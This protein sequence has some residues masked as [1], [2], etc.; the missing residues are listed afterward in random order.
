[1]QKITL[2]ISV[3]SLIGVMMLLFTNKKDTAYFLSAEVYNQFDY[4]LELEGELK[5]KENKM[6]STL[7]SLENDLKLSYE[8][9][10]S[11]TPTEDQLIA[12]ERSQRYFLNYKEKEEEKYAELAQTY[13][14]QIWDRINDFVKEYGQENDMAYIF[15]ANGDGSLMYANESE[16]ISEPLIEYINQKY[17]GS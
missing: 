2:T 8:H 12:Y 13:Y 1:M 15:G 6:K 10:K 11:I 4:K 9:L 7:D 3:L 17:N 16:D 5:V 14:Q